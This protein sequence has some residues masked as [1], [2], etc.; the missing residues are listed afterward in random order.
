MAEIR[1]AL[2][3]VGNCAG[4]LVEGIHHYRTNPGAPGLLF[5]RL[6]GFEVADINIVCA[7][8]IAKGKVG[9]T[10][11]EAIY[12]APNN[13]VRIG[14]EGLKAD[15]NV[16]RGPT[17]DGNPEHLQVLVAEA[18]NDAVDVVDVLRRERV[19][20][21]VNLLPTGSVEATEFY[22]MA[23]LKAGAAFVNCIPTV[24]AQRPDV[25]DMFAARRL[26]VLGD[27]IKSQVGSTIIHRTLL[28]MF[29]RRGA[30]ITRSSQVNVG[31][32]T[33]FANFV[34]RAATKLVSKRKSLAAYIGDG[35]P[36]HVGHHY[37]PTQGPLKRTSF[38]LDVEVFAGSK[39]RLVVQLES[40]DKP[41]SSGS[42]IDLVRIAKYEKDHGRGGVIGE[43]CA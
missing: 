22:G 11:G 43:G 20:V 40:D 19:D 8:D 34:H 3:G 25:Q 28:D 31:G 17:L 1:V 2:I 33:D 16:Y 35:T 12:A 26:P 23:A 32:N 36:S 13:F 30:V 41:N 10:L 15:A 4:S 37:D 6:G 42:V 5:P 38:V 14:V 39:V 27:D 24:F 29:L 9:L 7:F 21:V 18:P